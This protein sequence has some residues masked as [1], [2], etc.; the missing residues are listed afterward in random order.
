MKILFIRHGQTQ[1][2][3]EGRWLGSTDAPLS[4]NGK[5]FLQDKK[6]IIDKYKPIEKLYLSPMKRCIETADIYFDDIKNERII[7][8]DLRERAFG[9]FEGKSHEQLKDNPHYKK[10]FKSNWKSNVPNGENSADFFNRT[11]NAYL[12]I[13][14]DMK[15]N[16]LNYT[17]I[18]SHGGVIMSIFSQYDTS[19]KEFY[20]YLLQNGCGYLADIDDKN[21]I[22]I[23]EKF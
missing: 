1:L 2:N 3:A 15:K 11:K 18:V 21:Y 7:I 4:K 19:K 13:I 10:F 5:E 6:T 12:Y 17:A 16:Y 22:N 20:D 23:I 9:D 14:E 8:K